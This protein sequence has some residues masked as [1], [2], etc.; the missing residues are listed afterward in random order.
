V[1]EDFGFSFYDARSMG[2]RVQIFRRQNFSLILE[3]RNDKE[4]LGR[5][6]KNCYPKCD[7]KELMTRTESLS[8]TS[9]GLK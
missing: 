6:D 8:E 1:A 9:I 3:F 2:N 7:N 4:F 5:L